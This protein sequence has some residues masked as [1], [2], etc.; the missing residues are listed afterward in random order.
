MKRIS[1]KRAL[2]LARKYERMLKQLKVDNGYYQGD[3]PAPAKLPL[4]AG[5]A[6]AR[7]IDSF[8]VVVTR[9]LSY[10]SGATS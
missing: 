4:D 6:L 3:D 5:M 2:I 9:L 10:H 7:A 1:R 8:T